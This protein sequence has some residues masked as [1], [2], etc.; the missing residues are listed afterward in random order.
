MESSGRAG[1]V[2]LSEAAY[3]ACGLPPG[4]VPQRRLDVKGKGTMQ[5][6]LLRVG[7][8]EE[9]LHRQEAAAAE[10]LDSAAVRCAS[11]RRSSSQGM[12]PRA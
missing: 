10:S 6:Y 2:Q 9:A 3:A 11:M 8:W 1:C 12:L 7:A 4:A 5:T